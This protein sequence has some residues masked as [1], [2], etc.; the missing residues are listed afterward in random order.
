VS[1]NGGVHVAVVG[2][3]ITGL[4]AAHRVLELRGAG[5][6]PARVEIFEAGDRLGGVIGTS[7]RDG[8]VFEQGPDAMITEK[9]WALDLIQ[10]LGMSEQLIGTQEQHRRSFIVRKGKLHPT[11]AGFYLL[12]PGR[13]WP[14]V[15]TPLM[16]PL[17][18]LRVGL[19]LILPARK[20][21]SDESLGQFVQR[22]LGREAFQAMAQPMISAI[23]GGDPMRLSL[24]ATFPRFR[25]MERRHGSLVRAMWHAARKPKLKES[26]SGEAS[27]ARYGMFA[28][29]AGGLQELTTELSRRIP[30]SGHHLGV[31]IESVRRTRR[32]R[33]TLDWET[34][35]AEF[36]AVILAVPAPRAGEM[37]RQLDPDLA[38]RL[39]FVRYGTSATVGVA[40][41]EA[42]VRHHLDGFGLVIP[43]REGMSMLGCTFAH[44][45]FAGRAPDGTVLLRAIHGETSSVLTDEDL[46]EATRRDLSRL[47]GIQ[48]EP[49]FSQVT[50]YPESLPQYGLGHLDLVDEIEARVGNYAGLALAGNA[51]RGVGIPDC[52]HSGEVAAGEILGQPVQ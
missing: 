43:A 20:D 45:K 27:G 44:R 32:G 8:F 25:E 24:Q 51:Y 48:G 6:N 12:A 13:L 14:L 26:E 21:T 16:S 28:S 10:R 30:A 11:P 4:A 36:D 42:N 50:R 38:R 29:L 23:Y 17:G 5:S 15:T 2:G 22:R 7:R 47:L 39:G 41:S 35:S 49:M 34:G 40:Y 33:W 52:V 31:K 1:K 46:V 3:G 37:L 9:P 18:K 19:D